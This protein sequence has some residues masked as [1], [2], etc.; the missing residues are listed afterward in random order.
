MPDN[1]LFQVEAARGT[2]RVICYSHRHDLTL[3]ELPVGDIRNV[4]DVWVEQTA[5]LG[6]QFRW[7]Q[8]FENK[9]EI[10]GC[11]N[12]HPHG[13]IWAVDSLP[14]IPAHE[15]MRQAEY[16]RTQGR[17]LLQ[18]LLESEESLGDRMVVRN[19]SWSVLVPYWAAWPYEVLL[20]PRHSAARFSDLSEAQRDDLADILKRMLAK[21]DHLFG[22]SFPYS[23]GWHGAPYPED[24]PS[25]HWRLHA[26]FFPPLLRSATV[27]KFM[28]GFEMLAEPQRDL[29][30]EIAA[31]RLRE[32]PET[33]EEEN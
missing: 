31:Q 17:P 8:V 30:P 16:F 12:P 13:Q 28:V 20:L 32:L 11:S 19:E 10:M 29:T 1:P 7:V 27:K 3:P 26:H 33:L 2:S 18:D 22:V 21:Y 4:V 5:E 24:A 9:G 14:T 23:M 25:D 6:K 15:E